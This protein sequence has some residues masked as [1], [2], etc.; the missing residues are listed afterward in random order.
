MGLSEFR[1]RYFKLTEQAGIAIVTFA[2]SHISDEDNIEELGHDLFALVDQH[3]CKKIVLNMS[4]VE[5]V[6]SSVI[7]KIITL[8]RKLHRCEGQLIISNLSP[9][10]HDV[11][12]AS[13]L[14]GY[15]LVVANEAEA[16]TKLS[17]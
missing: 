15:F 14:L 5:Y 8:H 4:N 16:V 1:P 17:A 6:T 11:L 7:G 13:R 9:G 2:M 3:D 12:H 10:V